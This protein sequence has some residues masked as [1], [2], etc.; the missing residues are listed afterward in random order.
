MEKHAIDEVFSCID[1][2][3]ESKNMNK[4]TISIKYSSPNIN[5][6]IVSYDNFK[7]I[8]NKESITEFSILNIDNTNLV[9]FTM[10][11]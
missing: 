2:E 6:K 1:F 7:K 11:D 3:L 10:S 4:N 9:Q 5:D 8:L